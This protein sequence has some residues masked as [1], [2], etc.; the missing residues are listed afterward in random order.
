M[1]KRN[2]LKPLMNIRFMVWGSLLAVAFL[3]VG[4]GEAQAQKNISGNFIS[5]T[6]ALQVIETEA[7][8]ASFSTQVGANVP[9][10]ASFKGTYYQGIGRAIDKGQTVAVALE[11][12]HFSFVDKY[13][14]LENI[15]NNLLNDAISDLT[16]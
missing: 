10:K 11:S 9:S 12:N 14:S 1:K 2:L 15:A 6:A 13:P 3:F 4:I 5:S 8:A 7:T 16:E